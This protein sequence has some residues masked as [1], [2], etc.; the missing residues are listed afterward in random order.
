MKKLSLASLTALSFSFAPFQLALAQDFELLKSEHPVCLDI[1]Y[2]LD[3][4]DKGTHVPGTL[5]LQD[6]EILFD[7]VRG[8]QSTR[9][10]LDSRIGGEKL[11]EARENVQMSFPEVSTDCKVEY[12]SFEQREVDEE[13]PLRASITNA[14]FIV[15]REDLIGNR[16]SDFPLLV[17]YSKIPSVDGESPEQIKFTT[18]FS[19]QNAGKASRETLLKQS[20]EWTRMS[21]IEWTYTTSIDSE[22]GRRVQECKPSYL[23]AKFHTTVCFSGAFNGKYLQGSDTPVVYVANT[24]NAFQD[25]PKGAQASLG[26]KGTSIKSRNSR[27]YLNLG[28]TRSVGYHYLPEQ[29]VGYPASREDL[30]ME[31]PWV[32]KINDLERE[33]EGRLQDLPST[34]FLFVKMTKTEDSPNASLS[35]KLTVEYS[36][37]RHQFGLWDHQDSTAEAAALKPLG[38]NLW[39]RQSYA[40]VHI[41]SEVLDQLDAGQA[42][43][44]LE[45][46]QAEGIE[47]TNDSRMLRLVEDQQTGSYRF[48]DLTD[49][50][51]LRLK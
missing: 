27:R 6:K 50:L 25:K 47:L 43:G 2:D 12:I 21:D 49:N 30:V 3:C 41:P 39:N 36:Q 33:R 5:K 51:N 38:K 34:D 7:L 10:I 45:I 1:N 40:S 23:E 44:T 8:K 48:V 28:G 20:F 31:N 32:F 42:E 29:E 37:T 19:D 46:V 15:P 17:G 24:H 13:S 9:V 11:N 35:P 14:P 4:G 26:R 16:M 22:T 18:V